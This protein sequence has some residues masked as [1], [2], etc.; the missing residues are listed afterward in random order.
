MITDGVVELKPCPFC[1]SREI[2]PTGWA[3]LDASGPACDD[4]GASAGQISS[5]LADNIKAW[6][7]RAALAA[8]GLEALQARVKVLEGALE[9]G[10]QSL[11]VA[12]Y[13]LP[14]MLER[15][16]LTDDEGMVGQLQAAVERMD[17]ALKQESSK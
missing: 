16:A 2:D 8:S 13:G 12:I 9:D 7:T 15:N 1:G 10:K 17:E 11:A 14:D 4:C 5:D 6:N 3:S